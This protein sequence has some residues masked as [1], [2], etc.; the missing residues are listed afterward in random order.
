MKIVKVKWVDS[1]GV[2]PEWEFKD[3]LKPLK[4]CRCVSVGFL[5]KETKTYITVAQ[6]VGND[7]VVGRMT[8]PK[9]S[10]L[11]IKKL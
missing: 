1:K 8:I 6:S 7:Q 11:K 4:P 3:E 9:C 2:T 5:I 10:I